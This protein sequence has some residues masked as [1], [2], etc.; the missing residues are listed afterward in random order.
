MGRTI[1]KEEDGK[2]IAYEEGAFMDRRIGEL[3]ENL[4]GSE[5]TD[6]FSDEHVRIEKENNIFDFNS[7]SVFERDGSVDGEKGTFQDDSFSAGGVRS[8]FEPASK[9][10]SSGD[11]EN[12]SDGDTL[13]GSSY[14]RNSSYSG[15]SSGGFFSGLITL[16]AFIFGAFLLSLPMAENFVR[17]MKNNA[18]A[19][20]ENYARNVPNIPELLN[21][22]PTLN[23]LDEIRWIPAGYN[24]F[25]GEYQNYDHNT[26]S[27]INTEEAKEILITLFN[28]AYLTNFKEGLLHHLPQKHNGFYISHYQQFFRNENPSLFRKFDLNNDGRVTLDEALNRD[29]IKRM[30]TK[31]YEYPNQSIDELIMEFSR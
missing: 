16:G 28:V 13:G 2:R 19:K 1:I 8:R 29:L 9:S 30:K 4:D 14:T 15:N 20:R 25:K 12:T 21:K 26:L 7:K 3:H 22:R 18:P 5:E 31:L 10:R 27:G 17:D 24:P 23:N 6:S 11:G